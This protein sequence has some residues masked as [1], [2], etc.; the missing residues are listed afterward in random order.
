[1]LFFG[2]QVFL[3]RV[4]S[5]LIDYV[6]P[7]LSSL[8]RPFLGPLIDFTVMSFEWTKF[9]FSGSDFIASYTFCFS[10]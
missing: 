8:V 1:M 9:S 10:L 3:L 7:D 5:A 4:F 6:S 2:Y